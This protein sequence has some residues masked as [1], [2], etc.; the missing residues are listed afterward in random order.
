MVAEAN[1]VLADSGVIQRINLVHREEVAYTEAEDRFA[2]DFFRLE[3]PADGHL[4]EVH[5]LR[6]HTSADL[7]HLVR[8][9]AYR[10]GMGQ[11]LS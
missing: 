11:I 8:G 4:D 6:D 3:H 10:G 2:T 9:G 1:R 5:A 7:M